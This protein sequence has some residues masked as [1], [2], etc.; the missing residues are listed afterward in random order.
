MSILR[1]R[2]IESVTLSRS[3]ENAETRRVMRVIL[4]VVGACAS[5]GG[6]PLTLVEAA[7]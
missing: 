6:W 4:Q 2:E 1:L 3:A 5:S 7:P